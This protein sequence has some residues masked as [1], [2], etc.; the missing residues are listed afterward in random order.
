MKLDRRS[1]SFR[2]ALIVLLSLGLAGAARSLDVAIKKGD[3]VGRGYAIRRGPEC[4]VIAPRHVTGEMGSLEII[5]AGKRESRGEVE[6]DYPGFDLTLSRVASGATPCSPEPWTPTPPLD[7]LFREARSLRMETR[8]TDGSQRRMD[9]DIVSI[10]DTMIQ[11][12]PRNAS[13][14]LAQGMSGSI[15]WGEG[16]PVAMLVQVEPGSAI[17]HAMRLDRISEAIDPF[18]RPLASARRAAPARIDALGIGLVHAIEAGR[19]GLKVS[20]V[21]RGS[22]LEALLFERDLIVKIDREDVTGFED[23]SQVLVDASADGRL[24]LTILRGAAGI[25]YKVRW[26]KPSD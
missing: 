7:G 2:A 6:R 19:T 16:T 12:I 10:G 26:H 17:G 9:L 18:M 11:V 24:D 4:F 13:R 8:D 14:R 5:G 1:P 21:E 3:R 25:P 20:A 15:L 23:P 22:P